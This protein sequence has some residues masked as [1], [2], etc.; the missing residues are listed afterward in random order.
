[1]FFLFHCIGISF[2]LEE[3]FPDPRIV[4]VGQTGSGKSSLANALFGCDPR[5]NECMFPTCAGLDSCT[6]STSI[7]TGDWLGQ[8]NSKLTIVD[9][10]GFGD[11]QGRDDIFM[12]E[13]LEVLHYEL[14]YT[15]VIVLA[16]D[17]DIDRFDNSL[18]YMMKQM[19]A[20]FGE[21][22]WNYMMVGVTKWK[23]DQYHI[24]DRNDSCSHGVD[25]CK[26][27]AWFIEEIQ[28]KLREL[29]GVEREL[30]FA[31]M[32][33]YSQSGPDNLE[34]ELQQ[35]YWQQETEK[36]WREATTR[37][38]TFDFLTIDDILAQN[39]ELKE[40]NKKQSAT[41]KMM[42]DDIDD[43]IVQNIDLKEEILNL[44]EENTKLQKA[45]DNYY[46]TQYNPLYLESII[47]KVADKSY[48]ATNDRVEIKI[49]NKATHM[50]C[51]IHLDRAAHNDFQQNEFDYFD[52]GYNIENFCTTVPLGSAKDGFEV[53]FKRGEGGGG[54]NGLSIE[55][56]IIN[57]KHGAHIRCNWGSSGCDVDEDGQFVCQKTCPL[58]DP[59]D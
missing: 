8:K 12:E 39:N 21:S 52:G 13:M 16:I 54:N 33:S 51:I 59:I 10:P 36:L 22:W 1:L 43:I 7:G 4:I 28:T 53:S 18:I 32:D 56:A 26:N 57:F 44:Q 31:F 9:T 29:F 27:E 40:E 5:G 15:N 2:A 47:T 17:A 6:N 20:M 58:V 38:E 45:K 34:D 25:F 30:T 11:S 46:G 48:A 14:K 50:F 41:I 19:S 49:E 24:N 23:Y 55:M 42:W 37:N 3:D 35:F